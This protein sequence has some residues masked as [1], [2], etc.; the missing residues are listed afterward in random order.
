MRVCPPAA[1]DAAQSD[2]HVCARGWVLPTAAQRPYAPAKWHLCKE[3][4]ASSRNLQA[5]H[6]PNSCLL[7]FSFTCHPQDLIYELKA[8]A[9]SFSRSE[10]SSRKQD[11]A[12]KRTVPH[13]PRVKSTRAEAG[14]E[15]SGEAAA[16]PWPSSPESVH[17]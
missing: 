8:V 15:I 1:P 14:S 10:L 7:Y 9:Y 3:Q 13:W 6:K 4:P 16:W 11:D 12:H 17:M 5:F 2:G